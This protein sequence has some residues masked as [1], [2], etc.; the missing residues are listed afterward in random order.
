[1]PGSSG[2]NA[3]V[4]RF[5]A[6]VLTPSGDLDR[7]SLARIVFADRIA[8]ADLEAIIHPEV[9]RRVNAWFADLPMG[10]R[11]AIADVPLLYETGHHHDFDAVIVCACS[12]DEQIRRIVAR[13][14]ISE[15]EARARLAAQWPIE[16]K[17]ARAD[18]VIRT[19]AGFS[20]TDAQVNAVFETLATA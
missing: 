17:V 18:Y 4:E 5:G 6:G 20:M 10:T 8:R 11:V 1:M 12:P 14:G 16:E 7:P 19:D 2:L 3:V 9:Y 15:A 13:D